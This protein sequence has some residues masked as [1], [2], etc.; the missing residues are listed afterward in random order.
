VASVTSCDD[1]IF[2]ASCRIGT[3]G[4][5]WPL[6]AADA[7]LAALVQRLHDGWG[8]LS[9]MWGRRGDGHAVGI[10][11]V[12]FESELVARILTDLEAQ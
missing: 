3:T 10:H 8:P 6:D 7:V 9:G 5:E 2:M 4:P 12:P 1:A 11:A